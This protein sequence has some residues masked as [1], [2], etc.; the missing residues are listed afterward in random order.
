ML[1]QEGQQFLTRKGRLP[2][3]PD[4]DTNPPGVMDMLRQKKDRLD[5]LR[6]PGQRKMQQTFNEIFR[7]S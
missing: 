7:P 4:V 3:R 5:D 2:T 1:S 6:R